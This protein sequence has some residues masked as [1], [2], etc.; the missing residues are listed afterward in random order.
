MTSGNL[1]KDSGMVGS[2]PNSPAVS[3][4]LILPTESITGVVLSELSGSCTL[5]GGFFGSLSGMKAAG[6]TGCGFF[7]GTT[8]AALSKT[9]KILPRW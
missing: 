6:S 9:G 4:W 5:S 7:G 3:G 2:L 1:S 8:S